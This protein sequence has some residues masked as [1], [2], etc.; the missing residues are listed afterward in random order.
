M[1]DSTTNNDGETNNEPPQAPPLVE[2][3][4]ALSVVLSFIRCN[5]GEA[6]MLH[7][8][9]CLESMTFSASNY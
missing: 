1:S 3:I 7:Q 5:D 2:V 4:D 9:N 8:V 6:E